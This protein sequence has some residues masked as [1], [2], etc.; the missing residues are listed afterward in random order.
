MH[1]RPSEIL[2]SAFLALESEQVTLPHGCW[3]IGL[4]SGELTVLPEISRR[5]S[6][7]V[8]VWLLVATRY[9]IRT[10][11]GLLTSPLPVI[12]WLEHGVIVHRR[13]RGC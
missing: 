1:D 2:A 9:P 6:W 8:C 7:E 3:Q 4:G 13:G 5:H 11:W 10:E 12:N